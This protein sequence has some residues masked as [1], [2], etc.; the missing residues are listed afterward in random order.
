[1][2]IAEFLDG[3]D[4]DPETRRILGLAFEMS[5]KSIRDDFGD[6]IIADRIIELAAAGERDP[7][8]MCELTLKALR[9]RAR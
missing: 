5:R 6:K 3:R 4:F 1:M 8:R 2:S 7:D 9:E